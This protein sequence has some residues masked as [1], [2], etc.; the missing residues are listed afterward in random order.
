ML[1]ILELGEFF[2][3]SG[4]LLIGF[5]GCVLAFRSYSFVIGLMLE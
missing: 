3:C 5:V 4:I 2:F 1:F